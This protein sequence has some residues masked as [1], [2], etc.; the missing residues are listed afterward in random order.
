M[1]EH[2]LI[3]EDN[4]MSLVLA[5]YLLRQAGYTTSIASDGATGVRAALEN[6]SQLILCDLDLPAMDGPAVVAALRADPSWRRVPVLAFT[7][8]SMSDDERRRLAADFDGCIAKPIDPTTF[9]ATVAVH[10][11]SKLRVSRG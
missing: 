5:E 3:I 2:I 1:S 7:A 9:T 8:A 4:E 6:K 10:L 11:T